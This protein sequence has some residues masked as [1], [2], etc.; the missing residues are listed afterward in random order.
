[1][2]SAFWIYTLLL[3]A[4]ITA[5]IVLLALDLNVSN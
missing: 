2:P 4:L 5:S 3:S 1:M